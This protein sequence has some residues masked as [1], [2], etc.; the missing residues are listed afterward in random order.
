MSWLLV[1]EQTDPLQIVTTNG[2]DNDKNYKDY[3]NDR[4][5]DKKYNDKDKDKTI[6]HRDQRGELSASIIGEPL[7]N[8]TDP[9]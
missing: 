4:D 1:G 6:K 9:L 7:P 8:K 3:D 5:K 2:D